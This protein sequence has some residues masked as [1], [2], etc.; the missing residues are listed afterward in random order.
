MLCFHF[1]DGDHLSRTLRYWLFPSRAMFMGSAFG[2]RF[3]QWASQCSAVLVSALCVVGLPVQRSYLPGWV[4]HFRYRL[5]SIPF[6]HLTTYIREEDGLHVLFLKCLLHAHAHPPWAISSVQV[7][8]F[9]ISCLLCGWCGVTR[10]RDQPRLT[11]CSAFILRQNALI[12]H[13]NSLEYTQEHISWI[14]KCF[15]YNTELLYDQ[16]KASEREESMRCP[17]NDRGL[18]D[19]SKTQHSTLFSPPNKRFPVILGKMNQF[20]KSNLPP[21]G[22]KWKVGIFEL[23]HGLLKL[24][25]GAAGTKTARRTQRARA[26]YKISWQARAR[27][28]ENGDL[29]L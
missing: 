10:K 27:K 11:A 25:A 23:A 24:A 12:N 8:L 4:Y 17:G 16:E 3:C 14:L 26:R 9:R 20:M 18:K 22:K 7:L 19:S 6:V 15:H 28:D 29:R 5:P 21:L 1:V 2:A 13:R